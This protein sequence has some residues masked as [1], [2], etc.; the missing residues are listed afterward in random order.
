MNIHARMYH[1]HFS[2]HT[3]VKNIP[4]HLNID[5]RSIYMR[6]VRAYISTTIKRYSR[7]EYE[8]NK[9]LYSESIK[10]RSGK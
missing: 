10:R 4:F 3:K 5:F 9:K 8:K 2:Y 1:Q 6:L 7:K